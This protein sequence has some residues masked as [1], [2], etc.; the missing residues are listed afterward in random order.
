[1][2]A[3]TDST[4]FTK[5]ADLPEKYTI[6]TTAFMMNESEFLLP[7]KSS[8]NIYNVISN[9]WTQKKYGSNIP[10]NVKQYT[11]DRDTQCLYFYCCTQCIK[12]NLQSHKMT[13]YENVK[14]STN[15]VPIKIGSIHHIISGFG[16]SQHD[17][18]N[19]NNP[20][21]DQQVI[22]TFNDKNFGRQIA[23][24]IHLKSTQ[25][26]LIFGGYALGSCV[27]TIWRYSVIDKK[28]TLSDC[29]LP[30]AME[31]F[32]IVATLDEKYVIIFGGFST[33]ASSK[34]TRFDDIYVLD[35]ENMKWSECVLKCP[36]KEFCGAVMVGSKSNDD[37]DK[38]IS[39]FIRFM[40]DNIDIDDIPMDVMRLINTMY[41]ANQNVHLFF[42]DHT[43]H[44]VVSVNDILSN[45]IN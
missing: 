34:D 10:N 1:M 21:Q 24:G 33:L 7:Q 25:E 26:I 35:L 19:E 5:L 44:Y 4:N 22:R 15:F 32:G 12:L 39:G 17:I 38:I 37:N 41:G 14:G 42:H 23:G 3:K 28:W 13:K 9:E 43:D 20:E 30:K 16:H 2:S 31:G 18:W 8:L 40:C 27:D 45:L 36:F 11:Y 29:K 6:I